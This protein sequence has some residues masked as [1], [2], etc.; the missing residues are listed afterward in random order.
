MNR[1]ELGV[2]A[3]LTVAACSVPRPSRS[4]EVSN[5]PPMPSL[6]LRE[7][8]VLTRVG[9]G[10]C[11][12]PQFEAGEVWDAITRSRPDAFLFLGDNVYQS[13]E[14]GQPEL[15][16]LREAY[17]SLAADAWFAHLRATTPV[18]PTWDDHDYGMN[19]AGAEFSARK[20]SEALFKHVW[21]VR[22]DDPRAGREGVYH[23]RLVGRPGARTQIM[24][25]DTRYFRTPINMLGAA[26]WR[27]L[28][29]VLN[30]PADVRILASS[31]PVLSELA[32]GETWSKWPDERDRLL[33]LLDGAGGVV[34]VSGDSHFGAHYEQSEGLRR[35]LKE[36]TSSSLNFPM[37]ET[38]WL[39]PGPIDSA[40]VGAAHYPANFGAIS[41]DW[42]RRVAGLSLYD[43]RGEHVSSEHASF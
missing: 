37:P 12:V 43:H 28:E 26:Q 21:D 35:P 38:A 29:E 33:R 8:A 18:L 10:S 27:W 13:E 17:A 40:R 36:L 31:I 22:T 32:A 3:C 9:F 23:H 4:V 16:E 24:V 20:E 25:L 1:R 30:E 2:M 5:P 6:L 41:I 34:I 15:L 11:Y 39:S 42:G 14:N 7:D 19:D